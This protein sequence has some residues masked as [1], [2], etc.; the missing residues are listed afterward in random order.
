M[1][2]FLMTPFLWGAKR[3]HCRSLSH[4]FLVCSL[5]AITGLTL[6]GGCGRPGV[7]VL[8]SDKVIHK[9]VHAGE[10]DADRN[11][12]VL[13][14]RRIL[15]VPVQVFALSGAACPPPVELPFW[16]R[17]I[18]ALAHAMALSRSEKDFIYGFFPSTVEERLR[19]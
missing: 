12:A 2:G 19:R 8:Q 4:R 3:N 11:N 5:W 17:T 10:E 18:A 16:R 15:D 14:L 13:D 1:S 6:F 9:T 7:E